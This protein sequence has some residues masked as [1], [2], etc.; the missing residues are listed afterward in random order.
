MAE[1][2]HGTFGSSEPLELK[3]ERI[4]APDLRSVIELG[5][6]TDRVTIGNMTFELRSLNTLERLKAAE[7]LGDSPDSKKLFDLNVLILAMSINSVNGVPLENLI[8]HA[9]GSILE[10][11]REVVSQLQPATMSKLLDFYT[12]VTNRADGQ[13]TAEQVKN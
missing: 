9:E 7:F 2:K 6:L 10:K 5:S 11:R 4:A 3:K 1:I 13:F 8:E 12:T